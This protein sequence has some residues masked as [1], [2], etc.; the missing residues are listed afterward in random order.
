MGMPVVRIQPFPGVLLPEGQSRVCGQPRKPHAPPRLQDVLQRECRRVVWHPSLL[1]DLRAGSDGG[2]WRFGKLPGLFLS[3]ERLWGAHPAENSDSA[4][5]YSTVDSAPRR[6]ARRLLVDHPTLLPTPPHSSVAL[7][8]AS[9]S[10]CRFLLRD[11]NAN[12]VHDG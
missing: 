8:L 9:Q 5:A 1:G 10:L 3:I 6:G 2:R 7:A 12:S 11:A 4:F